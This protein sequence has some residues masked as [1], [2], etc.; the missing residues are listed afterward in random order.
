MKLDDA[1]ITYNKAIYLKP[2]DEFNYL[3]KGSTLLSQRKTDEAMLIMDKIVKNINP[4]SAIV[5][6]AK[7]KVL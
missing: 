4:Q 3:N 7:G 1:I 6:K 2:N 5:L